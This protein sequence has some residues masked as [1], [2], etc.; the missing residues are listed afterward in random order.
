[1]TPSY[2]YLEQT[3]GL[4]LLRSLAEPRQDGRLPRPWQ[5]DL[6]DEQG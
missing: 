3:D 1:M 5:P 6:F 4:E 2:Q